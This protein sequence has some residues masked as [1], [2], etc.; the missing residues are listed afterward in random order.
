MIQYG[1]FLFI[2]VMAVFACE[3][4][5]CP[6]VV[7]ENPCDYTDDQ[8]AWSVGRSVPAVLDIDHDG[9]ITNEDYANWTY[10]CQKED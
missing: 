6:P 1:L 5:D 4:Q 9:A 7:Q 8:F 2:L 3:K 10:L